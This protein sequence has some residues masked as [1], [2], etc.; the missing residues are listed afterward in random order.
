MSSTWYYV[1][2][3][4]KTTART[5]KIGRF[6]TGYAIRVSYRQFYDINNVDHKLTQ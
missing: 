5:L 1:Y 4:I 2:G 3:C 6:I